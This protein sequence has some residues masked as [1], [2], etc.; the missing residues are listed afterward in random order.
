MSGDFPAGFIW[1]AAT[2]AH[3][4]E[5]AN[6]NSDC[7]ALEHARPSL[8]KEPSGDA[9][10]H[11]NRFG[12]DVAI[13]SAI[14]LKAYR[15]SIEWARIEPDQGAFAQSALDHYQRCIDTCLQHGV[16][17]ILTF[18]H[19]TNPLW[20]ARQGGLTN[21][22]FADWFARYCEKA[23][24]S[25]RGFDHACTI[26][27]LNLPLFVRTP[28][29]NRLSAADGETLTAA[30]QEA[31]G[32]SIDSFFI[33]TPR[34]A[35]LEHGLGAHAKGRDAIKAAH[36]HCQVGVTL[37][38]QDEQAEP[39]G[40]AL[41]DQ[42]NAD[43]YNECLDFVRGDDFIGVQTYTRVV[44]DKTGATGPSP[45]HPLTMMGYEDRPQAIAS[46]CRY[47]WERT[48]TPILITENG[49]A[50]TDDRRRGAFV[51]E[52]L[53]HVHDALADGV[54]IRGYLYWSLLDNFEWLSGY[55]PKFG[56]IGF[57]RATQRRHIKPSALLLGEIAQ[58]NSLR[59]VAQDAEILAATPEST[60]IGL[61]Q[62][63]R[64][65]QRK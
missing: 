56:L 54:D 55:G 15:F 31:L 18:H 49:W 3:Q 30:A 60:P 51:Q 36:P 10:D 64:V 14:G 63:A 44:S 16:A 9:A 27:E 41:R 2:A 19:F 34:E 46:T 7:W 20:V 37:A 53:G 61:N 42:R 28:L 21:P 33:M 62:P 22:R 29:L 25:L 48:Q 6:T 8:F 35:V 57:D 32:A 43:F 26:N 40:E 50:G 65:A 45:G 47:V 17:P 5:G 24:S 59:V 11:W 1:G 52:A 38:V 39:G 58:R 13:L 12:D 4:V 23:A